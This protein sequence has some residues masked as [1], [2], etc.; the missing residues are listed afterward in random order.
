MY[1]LLKRRWAALTGAQIAVSFTQFLIFYVALRG[2][3]GW[4]SAGTS[5]AAAFA[6]FA[7]SQLGLMIPIT[8]GGLGTVDAA[9]IALLVGFGTSVGVATAAALLWRAA[10]FIPQIL[11]GVIALVA[12]YRKAGQALAK[13]TPDSSAHLAGSGEP[14]SRK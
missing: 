10:S 1:A 14:G 4:D 13:P 5:F 9:M 7:I 6:A 12:W 8:P 3:E 11:I 2:I